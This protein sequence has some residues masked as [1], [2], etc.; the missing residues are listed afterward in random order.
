MRFIVE[1][2]QA[3][4]QGIG[5]E[6]PLGV[7]LKA[8]DQEEGGMTTADYA[9]LVTRL[10]AMGLVDYISLTAGDGGL[11]HGPMPRP[12]GEWLSLVNKIKGATELPIMHAG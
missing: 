1:T 4:R 11:H 3:M 2:L 10:E 8:H 7:R 5:D 6:I 12:D 9:E